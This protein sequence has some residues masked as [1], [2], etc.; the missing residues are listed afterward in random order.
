MPGVVPA[1]RAAIDYS[2]SVSHTLIG[3]VLRVTF[4]N[5]ETGFRVIKLGKIEGAG[6]DTPIAVVG[7]FPAVGPGTRV[8]VTGTYV[9]DKRHG[10]QFKVQS[11]V[12]LAPDTIKG[13]E[14]YLGSG[15][16]PGVGPGFAS[17][18]VA[19][20]GMESL[21]VLDNEPERLASVPGLGAR[22]VQEIK[23]A[24]QA[25]R[26][27]SNL[28]LLLQ[29]H[30]ASPRL[31]L[32]IVKRYGD[33]AAE[34]VQTSPYRLALDVR[35]VGFKTADRIA[36]SLGIAGDHP[37]RAQAGLMHELRTTSD[38]GHVCV[39]RR[40]IVERTAAMLAIDAAHVEAAVEALW[41]QERIVV[42]G[43]LVYLWR[44]HRA[45]CEVATAIDQLL[46]APG[47]TLT[48]LETALLRFEKQRGFQLADTQK[49][50]V[51]LCATE[52]VCVITGGPGVGKTTIVQAI[53]SVLAGAKLRLRLAAPTGRAAKR[54]SEAT[55]CDASTL[56]RLL[57]YDPRSLAFQR[58]R[59]NPLEVDALIIDEASM[60]D[61]PLAAA[62]LEALPTHARLV[63]VG[64][65][66]QLPSV[67][68]GAVLRDLIESGAVPTMRLNEI[69]R[70]ASESGIVKNAHRILV[71]EL[72]E[73]ATD[74]DGD[75]FVLTRREP[76]EA[77]DTIVK[78]VVERM[79][80]RFGLDPKRDIQVLTPMHKGPAGTEALN[81]RLQA[82]LNPGTEGVT[83]RGQQLRVGDKVMQTKNDYDRDVY[84][85]DVGIVSSVAPESRT[86]KVRFDGRE[87][88]YEDAAVEA[89]TL[90]YAATVHKSQGSEYPAVVLPLLTSHFVMLSRNLV[91]TGV[92]RAR[93]VCVLVADPRALSL[94]LAETRREQRNT[95]LAER[96]RLLA[97]GRPPA[98]E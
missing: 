14:K 94:A 71:G 16:L 49:K 13:L 80:E 60:V 90:A 39:A 29:T 97:E 93:R 54:L 36:R 1:S 4:E 19:K 11:L 47:H 73:G 10:K 77:A 25:Q 61:L 44:L 9:D 84:N 98:A 74:A 64:D 18:I 12:E 78:L 67:G 7:N 83:L 41:A 91:Y 21:S 87:V 45:E 35:G 28:M 66:D 52:K 15:V 56:H 65:N 72:P 23:D 26:Q 57:E 24:W 58:N 50:A 30:G 92:T 76:E 38:Q 53:V 79:S 6:T 22:R 89:L 62:L 85:G 42:E 88:V 82:A 68:A 33:R 5:E 75:F 27:A 69:F 8:R 81:Q 51:G 63:I 43:E 40:D 95:R 55:A 2:G 31:A 86:L 46:K 32:A 3:E 70:Q 20:F 17:R 37:E 34:I 96:L 48:G 59:D